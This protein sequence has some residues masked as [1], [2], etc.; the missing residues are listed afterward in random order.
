MNVI[1]SVKFDMFAA[2]FLAFTEF[3]CYRNAFVL[4]RDRILDLETNDWL[5]Y[6]INFHSILYNLMLNLYKATFLIKFIEFYS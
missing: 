5:S 3:Y 1:F 2:L 4:S 6:L